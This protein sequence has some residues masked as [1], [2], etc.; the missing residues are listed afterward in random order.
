[1]SVRQEQDPD[2]ESRAILDSDGLR[3][4]VIDMSAV[5]YIDTAGIRGLEALLAILQANDI[6]LLLANPS[7]SVMS[8]MD[9]SGL[10]S[11]I[12]EQKEGV[13][14]PHTTPNRLA[15]SYEHGER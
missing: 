2:D 9:T 11:S 6:Q 12:G 14:L 15:H 4:L 5:T 13:L 1:M 7:A 8:M 10:T 3:F